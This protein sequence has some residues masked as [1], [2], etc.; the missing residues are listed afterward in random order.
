VDEVPVTG[1]AAVPAPGRSTRR[2]SVRGIGPELVSAASDNDPTNVGTAA[3]VGAQTDY[4]LCWVALL[5]APLLAVVQA[6]AA[7]LAVVAGSDLQTLTV[8]RYGRRVAAA[9]MVSVVVVNA[10]TIAAD[11]GAGA[12][13]LGYLAGVGAAWLVAPLAVALVALLLI[14]RYDEVVAVLRYL[15]IGFLA[16]VVAVVLSH[17]DWPRLLRDTV[18]PALSLQRA[19]VAGA[20][21]I[22]GT[23]LTAYVYLWE[24]V[25]RGVEAHDDSPGLLARA[26]TGAVAGAVVTGVVFW[27]MLA[28]SAATLGRTHPT[29]KDAADA[30]RALRPVAGAAAANWFAAGLVVSAVVALPVLMASTAHVV[31][32]QFDW[33]R[34]LSE[35]VRHAKAFYAVLAASVGLAVALSLAHV[36]VFGMLVVASVVGGFGTPIGIV[37][38]VLLARDPLVMGDRPVSRRLAGAGWAVA[39]AVGVFALLFLLWA[40]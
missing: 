8:K 1:D 17:P 9:L 5:V 10:V 22:L 19:Q 33:R 34:G 26:R 18:V 23:T 31:G 29:V 40:P 4:R 30:A 16:F 37:L 36:S 38:L 27:S 39:V 28:A 6:I 20:L 14:G 32:A 2:W 35:P 7:Q 11:L 25:E 21:A 13:G 3:V 15:L 12:A 24:T